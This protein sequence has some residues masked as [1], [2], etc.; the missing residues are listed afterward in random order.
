MAFAMRSCEGGA[1]SSLNARLTSAIMNDAKPAIPVEFEPMEATFD[2]TLR[3]PLL[4]TQVIALF[5][6]LA[7]VLAAVGISV[8]SRSSWVNG[9]GSSRFGAPSVLTPST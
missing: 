4:R 1:N 5:A 8:S 3:Y 7:A 2:A 9:R 6:T